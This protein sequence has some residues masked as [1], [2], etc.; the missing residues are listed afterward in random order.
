ME[1]SVK[2]G[3]AEPAQRLA[4]SEARPRSPNSSDLDGWLEKVETEKRRL[5]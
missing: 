2:V 4:Q 3:A 5:A 1:M